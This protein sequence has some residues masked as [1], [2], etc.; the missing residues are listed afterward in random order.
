MWK[1]SM[2]IWLLFVRIIVNPITQKR[3][4]ESLMIAVYN[5]VTNN[6]LNASF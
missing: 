5:I 4:Y 1:S 6:A 3:L 2:R